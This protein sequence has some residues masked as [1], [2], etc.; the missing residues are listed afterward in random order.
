[1]IA[2]N[3][4]KGTILG[5]RIDRAETFFRRLAGLLGRRPLS[6]G[7]GLWIVRCR[8]V[9]SVGMR[10]PIDVLFLD[11]T[12]KVIGIYP[13]FPPARLTRFHRR[14]KGALELPHG[15]VERTGTGSGDIVEFLEEAVQ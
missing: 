9:H 4:T 15:I 1:M 12:G 6:A 13:G 14:A 3:R 11:E 8:S 10:Y 7:E 5:D 2:V